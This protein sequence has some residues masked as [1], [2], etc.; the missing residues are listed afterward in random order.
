MLYFSLFPY[1]NNINIYSDIKIN[2]IQI[3]KF[4]NL[5]TTLDKSENTNNQHNMISYETIKS[6]INSSQ[7]ISMILI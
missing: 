3:D 4:V 5:D 1:F 7:R 6:K 2:Q